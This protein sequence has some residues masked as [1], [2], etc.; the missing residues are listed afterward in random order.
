ML[1]RSVYWIRPMVIQMLYLM[2]IIIIIPRQ[3]LWCCHHGRA[4][5]RV[6]PVHLINVERRQ[7]AADPRPSQTTWAVSPPVHLLLLLSPKADTHFTVPQRVEGW[8]DLAGWLHT[9]MVYPSTDGHPSWYR[10]NRVWRSATTLIEANTLPLSQTANH[11]IGYRKTRL[12]GYQ[13]A[14]KVW[15]YVCMFQYN[16]WMWPTNTHNTTAEAALCTVSRGKTLH[17]STQ[18]R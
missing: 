3:Y 10:T 14:K 12:M 18:F 9:E 11:N 5:P 2:I 13:T 7:A 8:V 6:H 17:G 4:I 16:T 15:G 1:Y